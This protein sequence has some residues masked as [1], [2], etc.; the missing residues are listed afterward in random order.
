MAKLKRKKGHNY[1]LQKFSVSLGASTLIENL[2]AL[3]ILSLIISICL[4]LYVQIA[5]H[6]LYGKKMK[7]QFDF[8]AY[9]DSVSEHYSDEKAKSLTSDSEFSCIQE[10]YPLNDRL[11]ILH[12]RKLDSQGEPKSDKRYIVIKNFREKN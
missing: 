4:I 9:A 8:E 5:R 6:N 7:S 12:F 11:I 3:V 2:I 10:D 1:N